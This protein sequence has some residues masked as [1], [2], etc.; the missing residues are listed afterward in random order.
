[1]LCIILAS[2][3]LWTVQRRHLI[4]LADDSGEITFK[5][6]VKHKIYIVIQEPVLD[7]PSNEEPAQIKEES[8]TLQENKFQE[9]KKTLREVEPVMSTLYQVKE[10]EEKLFKLLEGISLARPEDRK[11]CRRNV[12]RQDKPVAKALRRRSEMF[13]IQ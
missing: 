5:E 10:M 8:A 2:R 13:W 12:L 7:I 1:M 4:S 11:S 6:Y 3:R 9:K